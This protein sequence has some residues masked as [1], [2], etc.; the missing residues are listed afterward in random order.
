[1]PSKKDLLRSIVGWDET[2]QK[3]YDIEKVWEIIET[4]PPPAP[5]IFNLLF[6]KEGDPTGVSVAK[7][8]AIVGL[9]VNPTHTRIA[10]VF[11]HL[12]QPYV[13]RR[14]MDLGTRKVFTLAD[15]T[16]RELL[17]E[18]ERR[19]ENKNNE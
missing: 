4:Q 12:R 17:D 18:I 14:Y 7:V 9:G 6:T 15:F 1:M 8:S 5:Q 19:I 11:R 10:R 16:T 2:E 13:R 3:R